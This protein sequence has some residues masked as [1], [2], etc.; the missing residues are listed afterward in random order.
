MGRRA[1]E[2]AGAVTGP[3]DDVSGTVEIARDDLGDGGIVVHD[4]DPGSGPAV[5]WW[6]LHAASLA[7]RAR[8]RH[9]GAVGVRIP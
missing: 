7:P 3:V 4:E 8:D 6:L 2:R 5:L 1:V 9:R